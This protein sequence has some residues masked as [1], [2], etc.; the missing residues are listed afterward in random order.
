[1]TIKTKLTTSGNSVAVRLPKAILEESGIHGSVTLRAEEGKIIIEMPKN[2]REGWDEQIKAMVK[3]YG[4]PT[5]EFTDMEGAGSD[6]LEEEWGGISY[7]DWCK[8]NGKEV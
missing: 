6:G 2:P 3:E 4:D 1:M 7:E 8:Q 5:Q